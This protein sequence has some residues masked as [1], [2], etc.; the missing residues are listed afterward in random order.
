MRKSCIFLAISKLIFFVTS[1]SAQSIWLEQ[2][3]GISIAVEFLKPYFVD[4][5]SSFATSVLFFTGR[6]SI[7][8]TITIVADLPF[9]YYGFR[10]ESSTVMGNPYLGVEIRKQAS[11]VFVEVGFRL[12]LGSDRDEFY[13]ESAATVVGMFTDPDRFEA[14]KLYDLSMTVRL[15]YRRKL[16]SDFLLY[17]RSG[18]SGGGSAEQDY[19][20]PGFQTLDYSVQ[21]GCEIKQVSILGG[22]SGRYLLDGQTFHMQQYGG[23]GRFAHQLAVAASRRFGTVRPGIVF[24]IPIDDFLNDEIRFVLGLNVEIQLH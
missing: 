3:P 7:S 16:G 11:P 12:P 10:D 21:L 6:L 23:R 13:D 14:F 8:R 19:G 2:R 17:L 20:T 9:A 22:L 5:N 24:R 4:S 1:L 18:W 15:N